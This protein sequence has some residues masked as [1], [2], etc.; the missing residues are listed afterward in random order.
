MP[1][2]RTWETDAEMRSRLLGAVRRHRGH[3][4]MLVVTHE[5]V[6]KS[7]TLVNDVPLASWHILPA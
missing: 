7:A 6:I 4:S 3:G 5:T 1:P 2:H